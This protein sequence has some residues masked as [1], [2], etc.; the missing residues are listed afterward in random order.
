MTELGNY[1]W[2]VLSEGLV[3]GLLFWVLVYVTVESTSLYGA[4]KAGLISEAI[5]NLPYLVGEDAL[6]PVSLLMTV[7]A[8]VIFVRVIL[9]VGELSA[10]KATY[11][12]LTT[13]FALVALVSCSA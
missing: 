13:Y 9:R 2:G 3:I 8:A 5:G 7:V 11:G 1:L 12:V 10:L 6:G 4:L